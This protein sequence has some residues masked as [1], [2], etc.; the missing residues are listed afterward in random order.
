MKYVTSA[1]MLLLA[2]TLVTANEPQE[3]TA[4]QLLVLAYNTG[5]NIS[6][7]TETEANPTVSRA[8]SERAL[9]ETLGEVSAH[10]SF[11]LDEKIAAAM[12]SFAR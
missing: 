5:A 8:R 11:E 9:S 3:K 10:L 7:T 6:G 12:P 1:M 2:S 4:E